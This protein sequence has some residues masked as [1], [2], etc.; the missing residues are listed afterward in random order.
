[1]Q[2]RQNVA[3]NKPRLL[4]MNRDKKRGARKYPSIVKWVISFV[5]RKSIVVMTMAVVKESAA[6][7]R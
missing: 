2:L 6:N 4:V 3:L 5:W 7:P 1:M